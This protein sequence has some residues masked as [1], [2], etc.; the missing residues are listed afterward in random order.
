[1]LKFQPG[2]GKPLHSGPL[3]CVV[4]DFDGTLTDVEKEAEKFAE[5]YMTDLGKSTGIG[6]AELS[7]LWE[8]MHRQILANGDHGWE[9]DGKIVAPAHADPHIMTTVIAANILNALNLFM[10]PKERLKLMD[11]IFHRNYPQN[12]IVFREGAADFLRVLMEKSDACFVTSSKTASVQHKLN[13]LGLKNLPLVYGSAQKYVIDDSWS[14][15]PESMA[16]EGL[17]RPVFLRRKKYWDILENIMSQRNL[18]KGDLLVAGDIYELD[19]SLPH[20]FGMHISLIT[21][22]ATSIEEIAAV[23]NY[24]KGFVASDLQCLSKILGLY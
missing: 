15:V 1:M 19:L 20:F 5:R 6:E 16:I 3:K 12:R 18:G 17:C 21:K 13:H 9:I 4:L 24:E 8:R 11:S 2:N 7:L 23:S 10:E 22:T 14:I